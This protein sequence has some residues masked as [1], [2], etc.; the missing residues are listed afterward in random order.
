MWFARLLL[1][2]SASIAL[3]DPALA[4]TPERKARVQRDAGIGLTVTGGAFAAAGAGLAIASAASMR[5]CDDG[6]P[7]CNTGNAFG[8]VGGAGLGLVSVPFLA[9]GIPLWV[10][11]DK[12][13]DAARGTA[14]TV[15]PTR[16]GA[17]V[18][19]SGTF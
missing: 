14:L 1:V 2:C 7:D 19:L 10:I 8:V 3:F 15:R 18:S 9:V 4:A 13:L 11:G 16:G 12:R 6:Q 17:H 5:P